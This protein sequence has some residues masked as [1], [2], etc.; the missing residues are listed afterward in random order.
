[1]RQPI[2]GLYTCGLIAWVSILLVE[3]DKKRRVIQI[4]NPCNLFSYKGFSIVGAIGLEPM[5]LA[6]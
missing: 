3:A 6:L 4:K 2:S 1:M 5:T